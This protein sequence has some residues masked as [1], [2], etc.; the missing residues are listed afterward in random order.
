MVVRSLS[1]IHQFAK[2]V[3]VQSYFKQK[4]LII[5][6]LAASFYMLQL[7]ISSPSLGVGTILK[8]NGVGDFSRQ[9]VTGLNIAEV[10]V[11]FDTYRAKISIKT[12]PQSVWI[13]WN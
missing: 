2:S 7:N 11:I 13:C 5:V 8:P 6:G 12:E 10:V 9:V 3:L 1:Y 4:E